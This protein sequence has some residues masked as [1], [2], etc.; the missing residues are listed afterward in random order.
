MKYYTKIIRTVSF[1]IFSVTLFSNCQLT[2]E[3]PVKKFPNFIFI[4]SDDHAAQA[5]SCYGSELNLTPNLDKIANE[6][7]RFD[8]AFC[9]NSICTPSRATVLTGKYSHKN[10]VYHLVNIISD[11]LVTYP[12]LLQ[13]AGYY[14]GVI[15]KWHL[16]TEPKGFNYWKV[17]IEQGEY[18]DPHFC[19]KGK[20]WS[21]EEEAGTQYKGYVTDITTDFGIDFLR[22]R[23][24]DQP[25]CLLLHFKAPHDD[26]DHSKKY[27]TLYENIRIPEPTNL[28]DDYSNRGEAIKRCTQKIGQ[29]HTYY[30]DETGHLTGETREK[31]QYQVYV[32]KY[33]RCVAS[34]D[35]NIGR[36]LKYLEKNNL[37]ENTIVMYTSDQGFFLGEHGLYDKRFMYE[38]SLRIP[39]IVSYPK[40][41]KPGSVNTDIVTN[42]DFAETFLDYAGINIPDDMQ[43]Q[44]LRPLFKGQTPIDWPR[45]M[46]YRYWMHGAHFNVAAHYGIRTKDYKLI[47]YYGQKLNDDYDD[48]LFPTGH[49]HYEGNYVV[50]NTPEWE[51][52]DL[53]KDPHEMNNVYQNPKYAQIVK[54]LKSE[55]AGLKEKYEDT[56]INYPKMK[57]IVREYKD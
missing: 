12:K 53:K 29:N 33:L 36:V 23:P 5:L 24:K 35:E 41:I 26:W 50:D 49:W 2:K 43:G 28:L 57:D 14:T 7:I 3:K 6:G 34:I 27:D 39:F 18:H 48:E 45:A 30:E 16:H 10:G 1:V 13:E 52:F 47:F 20:G 21:N 46:Y 37:K 25:F 42:V 55:L 38:E 22:N 40:E 15:G 19:E 9:T 4:M 44:S 54:Q 51:L 17:M 31:E 11:S 32:K 56:D 8:N